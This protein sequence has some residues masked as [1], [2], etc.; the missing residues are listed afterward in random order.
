M[1]LARHL[2]EVMYEHSRW[3]RNHNE[4]Y[5]EAQ[6]RLAANGAHLAAEIDRGVAEAE[7]LAAAEAEERERQE[8]EAREQ[9]EAIARAA[10]ARKANQAVAPIDAEDEDDAYYRRKSW[11]V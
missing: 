10:A 5:E 7:R 4:D 3:L 2:E 1:D 9:R 6:R 11:L 8:E